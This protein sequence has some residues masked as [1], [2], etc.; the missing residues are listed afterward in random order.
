MRRYNHCSGA[1][2]VYRLALV[3]PF[4]FRRFVEDAADGT[5]LLAP[6]F[7]T[8]EDPNA[9]VAELKESVLQ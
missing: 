9:L 5:R 3:L 7:D 1:F 4:I 2:L 8:I 6:A